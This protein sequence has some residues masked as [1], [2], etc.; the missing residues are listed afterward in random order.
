MLFQNSRL[1]TSLQNHSFWTL[2]LYTYFIYKI[3][4]AYKHY[5]FI[6]IKY[7]NLIFYTLFLC[8]LFVFTYGICHVY[9]PSCFTDIIAQFYWLWKI[10]SFTG[11]V[12]IPSLLT[13]TWLLLVVVI[14]HTLFS[15]RLPL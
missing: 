8:L 1:I 7:L 4:Y 14:T 3:K 15:I 12:Y 10:R 13:L 9:L 2:S 6:V 11:T 5:E